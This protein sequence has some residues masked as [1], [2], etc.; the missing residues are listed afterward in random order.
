[1]AYRLLAETENQTSQ[2]QSANQK[3]S[4]DPALGRRIIYQ[5]LA[6]L[7]DSTLLTRDDIVG[8]SRRL[9]TQ[10]YASGEVVLQ[11]GTHGNCLG[12]VKSGQ[13]AVYST[14]SNLNNPI[15]LLLPGS[16]FGKAM[17]TD[18]LP[19]TTTLYATVD[20]E[21]SFLRRVDFLAVIRQ[22]QS[23]PIR[24]RHRRTM[25]LLV[26]IL[27]FVI[28]GALLTLK[29]TR[30]AVALA[31]Y[32]TGLWLEQYGYT[33]LVKATWT[34]AQ[35]MA[36]NWAL[37]H[38]SLGNLYFHQG[39]LERAK[40]EF[41]R[42][43]TLTPDLAETH[44]N[45]GL[46]YAARNDHGAAIEAYQQAL[47]LEPGQA[48]VEG[49]LAY[50]LQMMGKRDEALRHYNLAHVLDTPQPVLLTNEAIAHYEAGNLTAAESVAREVLDLD[51]TSAVAFAILGAVEL[52]KRQTSKAVPLLEKAVRLD[53]SYSP[54]HFYLGLAYKSLY[55]PALAAAAFERALALT[56]NA[57][58]QREGRRHLSELYTRY[59]I[60]TGH[61]PSY[62]PNE[63]R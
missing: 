58:T 20:A 43:L 45:L 51:K 39:Q 42:A 2:Q 17:L 50:S 18:G 53:H 44:N 33:G 1:M 7:S 14:V 41:E 35:R 21:I 38:L 13:L 28:T 61:F 46:I 15:A 40:V 59:A 4:I 62:T 8:L 10:H 11:E 54:A 57:L 30:Q 25:W 5:Q 55:R 31:P 60:D 52:T 36:P 56:T 47:A 23:Q 3:D 16:T 19:S 34:L 24:A 26:T 32:S 6:Q 48:T 49:N 29:P 9:T 12:L 37:P 27:A 63:R 22:Y